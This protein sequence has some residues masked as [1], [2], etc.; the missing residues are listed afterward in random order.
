MPTLQ[1][2]P[3]DK[4][5]TAAN[6]RMRAEDI[7]PMALLSK[8]EGT[9]TIKAN[10]HDVRSL[11]QSI[12]GLSIF[13]LQIGEDSPVKVIVKDVQRDPV[14]RKVIHLSVQEIADTDIIKVNIPVR[15]DGTPES[16]TKRVSTLM[17]P[18]TEIELKAKVADLPNE[19]VV[20]VSE[21]TENDRIIISDLEQ[22]AHLTFLTS[23]ETVL[24]TTKKLRS[25][26]E[27]LAPAGGEEGEEGEE[28]AE[29]EAS[30]DGAEA[31]A[32]SDDSGE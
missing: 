28:G 31:S 24:A 14:S 5:K 29:G 23:D 19:I 9:K 17:V 4:A 18:K 6:N 1:V 3:R 27:L 22:Y 25:M 2:E 32:D 11:I 7:L 8:K 12:D 26:E 16:V 20:D 10:R 15:I 30:E 21:M 13:D